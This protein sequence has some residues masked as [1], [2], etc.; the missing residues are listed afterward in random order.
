MTTIGDDGGRN[1]AQNSNGT[2]RFFFFFPD[3]QHW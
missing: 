3:Y 1:P 2:P